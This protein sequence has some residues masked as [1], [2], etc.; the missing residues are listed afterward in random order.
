VFDGA[1]IVFAGDENLNI[2]NKIYIVRFSTLTLGDTPVITL[3]QA[4]DG[5]VLANEQTVAF[6]GYNYQGMDFYFDGV[7]WQEGQQKTTVNQPPLF[8]VFDNNGISFGDRT[9]Y[10]GTSFAGN[11]LFAYGIGSGNDD[12]ILG[13][14]LLY[15]SVDNVGDISFDV[16]LNS[17]TFNYVSGTTPITQ[18][19]NTGYVYNY[20][21]LFTSVRQLGWQ[22]AVGP[23]VQYQIFEFDCY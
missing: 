19:V 16:S 22:T 7:N 11:K 5:L 1:R 17:Q 12:P 21:D 18:K 20:S 23:S 6:R 3:T 14:P 8:D 4:D 9:V 13:F 10:V 15:S 2:R